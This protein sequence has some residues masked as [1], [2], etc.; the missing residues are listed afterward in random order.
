MID[1]VRCTPPHREATYRPTTIHCQ[2]YRCKTATTGG[3]PYC[4]DHIRHMPL[5]QQVERELADYERLSRTGRIKPD[6]VIAQEILAILSEGLLSSAR[7]ARRMHTEVDP[8]RVKE[9]LVVLERA[10]LVDVVGNLGRRSAHSMAV[11][12]ESA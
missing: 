9:Y 2:A 6:D 3:K 5:V 11:L 1:R 10:G 8:E 12:K 4:H 7:I